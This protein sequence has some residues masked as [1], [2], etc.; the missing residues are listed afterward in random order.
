MLNETGSV[1]RDRNIWMSTTSETYALFVAGAD[2]QFNPESRLGCSNLALGASVVI[3]Q[4]I[5]RETQF[6]SGFCDNDEVPTHID[7]RSSVWKLFI[8][9][10]IM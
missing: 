10:I 8:F 9:I 7:G 5:K 2:F 1:E 6:S 4:T 3:W